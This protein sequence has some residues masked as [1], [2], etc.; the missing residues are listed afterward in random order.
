MITRKQLIENL[1]ARG[2]GLLVVFAICFAAGCIWYH[3]G[4]H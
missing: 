1:M 4:R 3:G 2:L